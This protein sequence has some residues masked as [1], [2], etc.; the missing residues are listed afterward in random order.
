MNE[1]KYNID[2]LDQLIRAADEI[3]KLRGQ[4][5][6]LKKENT[7]LSGEQSRV[8]RRSCA[9]ARAQWAQNAHREAVEQGRGNLDY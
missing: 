2:I 5:E 1:P 8:V 6:E 9:Y 3:E 4:I 7:H